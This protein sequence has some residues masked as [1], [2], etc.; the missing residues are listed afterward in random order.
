MYSRNSN[1]QQTTDAPYNKKLQSDACVNL[2][3]TTAEGK[4]FKLGSFFLSEEKK[5]DAE[6]LAYLRENT[7]ENLR[8]LVA[9]I[10]PQFVDFA[11]KTGAVFAFGSEASA[12]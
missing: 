4:K 7:E 3:I 6:I 5:A 10:E 12:P 9:N 2:Y 1:N 11:A 8:E